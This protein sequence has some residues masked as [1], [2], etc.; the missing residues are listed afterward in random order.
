[1]QRSVVAALVIVC[2][3]IDRR[4]RTAMADDSAENAAGCHLD[5]F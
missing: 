2:W 3:L 5:R 1:L 4:E